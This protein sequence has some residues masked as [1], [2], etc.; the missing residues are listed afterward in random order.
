MSVPE[1]AWSELV[2]KAV[3]NA[4]KVEVF[5]RDG[6][7]WKGYQP[8]S[9]NVSPDSIDRYISY[10]LIP[11]SYVA[12]EKLTISQR[13]LTNYDE[14]VIYNNKLVFSRKEVLAWAEDQAK[15]KHQ[16]TDIIKTVA[17]SA[18]RKMR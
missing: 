16:H 12:Y 7:K 4:I 15:P 18:R 1:E 13:D 10:R 5:A 14:T 9:V 3:G 6:E 8:F 17:R 2:G 11:P